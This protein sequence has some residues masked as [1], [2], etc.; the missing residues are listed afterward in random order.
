MI[1]NGGPLCA[2]ALGAHSI[3]NKPVQKQASTAGDT[4]RLPLLFIITLIRAIIHPSSSRA[5]PSAETSATPT[6][7][8][9]KHKRPPKEQTR[10]SDE[11][12][13][14]LPPRYAPQ[15]ANRQIPAG[16]I[17]IPMA[18]QSASANQSSS[19]EALQTNAHPD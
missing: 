6:P 2:T 13:N 14:L 18:E 4:R 7:N 5:F 3:E 1:G 19:R 15:G 12:R 8:P 11:G 17:P 16:G 9:P 10:A